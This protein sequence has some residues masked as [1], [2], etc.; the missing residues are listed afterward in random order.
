MKLS[1]VE[2]KIVLNDTSEL[3]KIQEMLFERGGK[4]ADGS[5]VVDTDSRI[6]ALIWDGQELSAL[7]N[8]CELSE[9]F[10]LSQIQ[11]TFREIN[12]TLEH[13]E[14]KPLPPK[15]EIVKIGINDDECFNLN[16]ILYHWSDH[17]AACMHS[18]YE[19]IFYGYIYDDSIIISSNIPQVVYNFNGIA[20]G[21]KI[22]KQIVFCKRI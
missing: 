20:S 21:I 13:V 2:F 16:G 11:M 7:Y 4:W 18:H 19:Y 10:K 9:F 6:R 3:I 5:D 22:P 1:D 15:W 8:I 17:Y 14:I 12:A